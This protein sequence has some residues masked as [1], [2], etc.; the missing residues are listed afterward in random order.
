MRC[1]RVIRSAPYYALSGAKAHLLAGT[2]SLG[3]QRADLIPAAGCWTVM[4]ALY[5][6]ERCAS[7]CRSYETAEKAGAGLPE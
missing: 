1:K 2:A 3:Q 4:L 6:A 5:A 7:C